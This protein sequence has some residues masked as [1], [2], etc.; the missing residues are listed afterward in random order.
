VVS[1]SQRISDGDVARAP[2]VTFLESWV[3]GAPTQNP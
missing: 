2:R 1:F 3:V